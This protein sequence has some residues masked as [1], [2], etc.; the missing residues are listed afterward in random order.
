[1]NKGFCLKHLD[2][3]YYFQKV[4]LVALQS[5]FFSSVAYKSLICV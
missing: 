2:N 3:P 5:V 1:M 4:A